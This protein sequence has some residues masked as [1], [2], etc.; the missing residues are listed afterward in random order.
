MRLPWSTTSVAKSGA[1]SRVARRAQQSCSRRGTSPWP[2]R[3]LSLP[4]RARTRSPP[5]RAAAALRKV[6]HH[7]IS[8][9]PNGTLIVISRHYLP[10][11]QPTLSPLLLEAN[12]R[13]DW[14]RPQG[15]KPRNS[16]SSP[17]TEAPLFTCAGSPL[18]YVA[19]VMAGAPMAPS[20]V[21][22]PAPI[23]PGPVVQAVRVHLPV[24]WREPALRSGSRWPNAW[25]F[26]VG[27]ADAV[28]HANDAS[29]VRTHTRHG[30]DRGA[31]SEP[32]AHSHTL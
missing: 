30:C 26:R 2:R 15:R 19:T 23:R 29:Y 5:R 1:S 8:R 27:P 6:H 21:S 28:G 10:A 13:E 3:S 18:P 17:S 16:R 32:S 11:V 9:K 7:S 22:A 4:R 20:P 25:S 24:S 14:M 31:Y 12:A